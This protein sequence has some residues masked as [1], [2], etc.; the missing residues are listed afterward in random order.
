M[1]MLDISKKT[2]ERNGIGEILQNDGTFC[3]NEKHIEEGLGHKSL[4]E[5]TTKYH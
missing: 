3:L 5:I 1:K 2:Y 4:R